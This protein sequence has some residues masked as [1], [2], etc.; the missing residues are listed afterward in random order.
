MDGRKW[1]TYQ[2]VDDHAVFNF[3]H[4]L[5]DTNEKVVG[6]SPVFSFAAEKVFLG[7]PPTKV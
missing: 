7:I 2:K 1:P 4:F 6:E 5:S 3:F